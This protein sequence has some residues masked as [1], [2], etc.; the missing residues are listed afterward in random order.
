MNIL[1]KALVVVMFA[2]FVVAPTF[3]IVS[4]P[5]ASA[6][7]AIPTSKCQPSFLG[8]PP[9]YRGLV[10]GSTGKCEIS[11]PGQKLPNGQTLDLSGYIWRIALNL[12]E[13]ALVIVGYIAFFFVLYGGF[14]FLTGGSNP[15]QIEKA[16]KSILNAVIGL[17]ISIGAIAIVNLI[18]RILG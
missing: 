13:I 1:K 5:T 15:A 16:R 14:Q 10:D 9:W 6:A 7:A 4:S 3:A 12:I 18:F 2:A 11:G 8:I 17:A